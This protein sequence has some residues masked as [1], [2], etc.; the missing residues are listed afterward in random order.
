MLRNASIA[1]TALLTLVTLAGCGAD[2]G[3][4]SSKDLR[5]VAS[6]YPLA[7]A[8]EQIVGAE[9][10]VVNLTAT[11]GEPHDLELG[12]QATAALEEA[13]LVVY[14]RGFQP[15]VDTGVD[16]VGDAAVVDTATL[17]PEGS[18]DPHFWLD[19][20]MMSAAVDQIE[21]EVA[22]LDTEEAENFKARADKLRDQLAEL[23]AQFSTGL[24][25]CALTTTIVS[26]DAYGYW[27]RYG[28]E[29]AP[30]TATP[31]AEPTPGDLARLEDLVQNEGLT[32]IFYE[33]VEGP[34]SAD[35]LAADV[36]LETAVLDPIEGLTDDTA[37][38]D[39]L[40]LM[41]ANLSALTAANEC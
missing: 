24:E 13:D 35:A 28:L 23:D 32:T 8:T 11:G 2:D 9:Y 5:I 34:D 20:V 22:K 4:E 17:L 14:E 33:P 26:H 10:D 21:E 18:E 39:Y 37:D 27:E 25:G 19:P 3:P 12:I 6:F 30:I 1:A 16:N 41:T 7:W 40:S 15:A 38:E 29:F 36:G 31:D